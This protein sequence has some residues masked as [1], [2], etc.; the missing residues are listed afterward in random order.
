MVERSCHNCTYAGS[1]VY[2]ND[3][4]RCDF[5]AQEFAPEWLTAMLNAAPKPTLQYGP[6]SRA[7]ECGAFLSREDAGDDP[8]T[9]THTEEG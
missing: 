5:L 6:A 9:V 7:K 1:L 8:A 3:E 2:R 4:R